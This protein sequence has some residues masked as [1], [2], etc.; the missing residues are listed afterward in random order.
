MLPK[1]AYRITGTTL[2]AIGIIIL[3]NS[4]QS[5]TGFVVFDSA[6]V[7][8]GY[9][10]GLW[11]IIT[12][13]LILTE[14]RERSGLE[15]VSRSGIKI[16][17]TRNFVKE[18]KRQDMGKIN[19]A[20]RRIG[21]GGGYEHRLREGRYA[22]ATSKGGRILFNYNN[23]RTSATLE[24]YSAGHDYKKMLRR[25]NHLIFFFINCTTSTTLAL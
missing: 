25:N 4:F 9:F 12:G 10:A 24:S 19:E 5:F 16:E 15:T 8:Y 17:P 6:E 21:S 22:I 2:L 18:V 3:L 14:A 1:R 7:N 13:I 20:I 11:L 23:A